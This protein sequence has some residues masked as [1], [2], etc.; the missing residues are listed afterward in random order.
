MLRAMRI[1][2][3]T[4]NPLGQLNLGLLPQFADTV[5]SLDPVSRST[6]ACTVAGGGELCVLLPLCEELEEED[7]WPEV[8][9]PEV[10]VPPLGAV[11]PFPEPDGLT[12]IGV[13]GRRTCVPAP[14]TSGKGFRPCGPLILIAT[15]VMMASF[16]FTEEYGEAFASGHMPGH[17]APAETCGTLIANRP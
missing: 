11:P 3:L 5:A 1:L 15:R 4:A 16:K 14:L 13:P 12:A 17:G 8:W 10:E 9:L 7:P 6:V 2:V